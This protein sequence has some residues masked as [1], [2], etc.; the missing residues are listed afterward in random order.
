MLS[1]NPRLRNLLNKCMLFHYRALKDNKVVTK[2]IEALNAQDVLA[3]LRNNGFLVLDVHKVDSRTLG[4][5]LSVFNKASFGTIVNF[6]RQMAIILNAGLTLTDALEILKKQTKSNVFVK[7]IES[8]DKDIRGGSTFAGALKKYPEYFPNLYVSLVKSGEVSGKLNEIM[9]KLAD[10]LEK[11]HEFQGKLKNSLIYPAVVI[12][13]MFAIMFIMMAFV[14]PKMLT[15]YKDFNVK[16]PASTKML[17]SVSEFSAA[18]WP[19]III[20]AIV[21]FILI[22][23]FLSTKKG[24]YLVDSLTLKIPVIKGVIEMAAL[25]DGTRTLSILTSA[26]VPIL[27]GLEI[28]TESTDNML[29]RD[30]FKNVL[31]RVEKGSSVGSAMQNEDIFPPILI[32]MT[33]VGEQTGH[34]DETM[35]RIST[36]FESES[37]LAIKAMTSLIE[38]G[39]LV[40]LGLGVGF[41]VLSLITPIYNLTSSF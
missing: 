15:L 8:I 32:Q 16:L 39:I 7:V 17:I 11:K 1:V 38:P 19:L 3:Y 18:F 5:Y 23:N 2:K 37:S 20:A 4:S 25:V 13:A 6:T 21:I 12:L 22:R 14:L 35:E 34:L 33:N 26:G 30:A 28:V 9:A 24:K 29:Y 27:E 36:Y 41:L 31:S 10:N 40:F